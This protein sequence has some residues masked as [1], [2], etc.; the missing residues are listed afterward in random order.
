MGR[1]PGRRA[2][3][4]LLLPL[5]AGCTSG[6]LLDRARTRET[7]AAHRGVWI[8]DARLVVAWDAT[9][10]DHRGRRVGRATRVTAV[11]LEPLRR[12][13]PPPVDTVPTEALSRIPASPGRPMP[14]DGASAT[15]RDDGALVVHDPPAPDAVLYPGT[16]TRIPIAPWVWP[17]LLVTAAIDAVATPVLVLFAPAVIVPGD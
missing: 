14:L 17:L 2:A 9:V 1:S 6:H 16:L 4:L 15:V 12:P 3:V 8:D 10:T 11:P 5:L 13:E 7:L